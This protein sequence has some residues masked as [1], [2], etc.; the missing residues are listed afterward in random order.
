MSYPIFDNLSIRN[1]FFFNRFNVI[2]S[3]G[4]LKLFNKTLIINSLQIFGI[5]WFCSVAKRNILVSSDAA[6]SSDGMEYSKLFIPD[7]EARN[8]GTPDII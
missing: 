1:S 5:D 3:T 4:Y 8:D 7:G 2:K 6:Y